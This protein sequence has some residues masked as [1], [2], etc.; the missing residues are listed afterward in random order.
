MPP[1]IQT[2]ARGLGGHEVP[3]A[4]S[5]KA[6]SP[7]VRG[8][9]HVRGRNHSRGRGHGRVARMADEPAPKAN[10]AG[11][12][13]EFHVVHQTLETLVGLMANQVGAGAQPYTEPAPQG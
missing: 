10:V 13:T 8:R 12:T 11:I 2:R 9:G 4:E 7:V 1:R 3:D 5:D 6:P